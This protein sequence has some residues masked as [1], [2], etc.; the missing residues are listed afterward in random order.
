MITATSSPAFLQVQGARLDTQ[1][2]NNQSQE[3]QRYNISTNEHNNGFLNKPQVRPE[4]F[5][6]RGSPL[7]PTPAVGRG[8]NIDISA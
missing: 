6:D 2:G 3:I 4:G 1:V 7:S 8:G 5:S